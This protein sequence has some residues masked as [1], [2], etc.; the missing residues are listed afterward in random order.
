[1]ASGE[2]GLDLL[3]GGFLGDG[4]A[5]FGRMGQ[6]SPKLAE[7]VRPGADFPK[8][9]SGLGEEQFRIEGDHDRPLRSQ[10]RLAGPPGQNTLQIFSLQRP[11]ARSGNLDLIGVLGRG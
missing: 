9:R 7:F 2:N 11:E 1:M 8:D 10:D 4:L 5:R 3:L 6:M